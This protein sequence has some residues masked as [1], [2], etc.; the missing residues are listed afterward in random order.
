QLTTGVR[1]TARHGGFVL[2]QQPAGLGE[3]QLAR[4]IASEPEAIARVELRDCGLQRALDEL[5]A[6]R[7]AGLRRRGRRARQQLDGA[8][9]LEPSVR[10]HRVDVALRQDGA[11][12]RRETAASVKV[13][14]EAAEELCPER[15]GDFACA[16]RG[17][18]RV[19][20]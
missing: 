4:M 19:C 13:A 14:E 20:G 11:Q 9:R 7:V 12:P 6:A 1:E 18:D 2:A 17:I 10:A 3:R 5:A 16:T 15:V 8:E